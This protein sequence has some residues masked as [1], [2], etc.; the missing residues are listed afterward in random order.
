M[1]DYTLFDYNIQQGSTLF[2]ETRFRSGVKIFVKTPLGKTI[3][4]GVELSENVE[5]IKAKI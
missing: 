4:L 5:I 1:D 2:A 3:T